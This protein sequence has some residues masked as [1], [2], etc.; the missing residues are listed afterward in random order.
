MSDPYWG[1]K[2]WPD[3]GQIRGDDEISSGCG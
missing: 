3:D 2:P 1:R